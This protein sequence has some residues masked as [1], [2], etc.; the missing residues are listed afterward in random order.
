MKYAKFFSWLYSCGK[1]KEAVRS[2]WI[3][4]IPFTGGRIMMW[5]GKLSIRW[6]GKVL[7]K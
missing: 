1:H 6:S 4:Q 2:G 3:I 5:F 7:I